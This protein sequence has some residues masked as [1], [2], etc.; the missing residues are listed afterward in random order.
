MWAWFGEDPCWG[1][2]ED[3]RRDRFRATGYFGLPGVGDF[4]YDPDP[5]KPWSIEKL[6]ESLT[7][8]RRCSTYRLLAARWRYHRLPNVQPSL[9]CDFPVST[10]M[11]DCLFLDLRHAVED[12]I[13]LL[14]G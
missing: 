3:T 12:D 1:K 6:I 14:G 7:S 11:I 9:V 2:S 8:L 4:L 10:R 5:V 13:D